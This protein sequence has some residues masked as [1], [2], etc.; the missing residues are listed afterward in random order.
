MSIA[1][2]PFI[3]TPATF[4]TC[5]LTPTQQISDYEMYCSTGKCM[6][7]AV[8]HIVYKCHSKLWGKHIMHMI[9]SPSIVWYEVLCSMLVLYR[10]R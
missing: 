9:S 8:C 10:Q 6:P 3:S 1:A 5:D 2:L 7:E 4:T